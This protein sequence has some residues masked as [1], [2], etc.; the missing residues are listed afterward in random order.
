M[1][2]KVLFLCTG[3]S[4]RSQMAE[5]F[6]RFLSPGQCEVFSAGTHPGAVNPLAVTI[7]KEAGVDL[8]THRSKSL[9]EFRDEKF[10]YVITVCDNARQSCPVFPGESIRMHWNLEDPARA[11]GSLEERLAVFRSIR[12]RI[13]SH[14]QRFLNVVA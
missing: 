1:K 10:D 13:H 9:D 5:G 8:T 7:M 4:C 6:L 14:V 11:V 3:N 2:K 12:D